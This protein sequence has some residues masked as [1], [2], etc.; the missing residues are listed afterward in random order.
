MNLGIYIKSNSE[1][2]LT[3]LLSSQINDAVE[4]GD[5]DDACLFYDVVGPN[6]LK[7]S[8]GAFNST[9]IWNRIIHPVVKQI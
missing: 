6:K 4:T 9:D 5:L 7:Y 3:K 8:F 1:N 2:E